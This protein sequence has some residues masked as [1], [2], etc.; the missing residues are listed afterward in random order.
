MSSRSSQVIEFFANPLFMSTVDVTFH[1][2]RAN[3]R[4]I[5]IEEIKSVAYTPISHPFIER[6]IGTCRRELLDKILFW[7]ANDLQNKLNEFLR[8]YNETR[9]HLGISCHTPEFQANKNPKTVIDINHY[10]WKKHCR[11]LFN[12]PVAA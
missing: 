1:R 8:Y 10:R 4:V 11:G 2:W 3:L 7:N 12:L 5:D 9:C 6:V